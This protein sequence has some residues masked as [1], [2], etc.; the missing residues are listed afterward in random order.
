MGKRILYTL[1]F[2][3]ALQNQ[4]S[5]QKKEDKSNAINIEN[6]VIDGADL[7]T[8]E[9]EKNIFKLIQDLK[10]NVGSELAVVTISTLNGEDINQYS[11]RMS[12]G[13]SLGREQ[14]KD[15]VLITVVYNDRQARIEV[16]YGLE[17]ILKDEITSRIISED[18]APKFR[19]QK[20]YEGLYAAVST[21]KKL[22]EENKNLVGQMP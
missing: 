1:I 9:Q 18:M 14:Y 13:L 22:I 15:G 4:I 5:C 7:L 8:V 3:L 11:I 20:V 12:E 10:R 17:K 19:E 6:R 16:G 21:V 2:L